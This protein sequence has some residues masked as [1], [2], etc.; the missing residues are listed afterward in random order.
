MAG[1]SGSRLWPLSRTHYPKQFLK[2]NGME[3]SIFQLTI[4][5]CL[6]MGRMEDIYIVSNKDYLHLIQ[7][8]I[9]EMGKK[10]GRDHILLEP[11]PKNTLPAIMFAIQAIRKNCED[12]CAVFASDHVM[13][14]PE[15]LAKTVYRC[16]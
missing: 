6:L 13:D 15:I 4:D 8:Q 12:I 14:H 11:E 16:S 5:R 2:L 3:K 7:G 10:I 1:G 9:E